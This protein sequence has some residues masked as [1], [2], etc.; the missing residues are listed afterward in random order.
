[1][2]LT[3]LLPIRCAPGHHHDADFR[4]Y[5][6]WVDG[7]S[8][9]LVVDG[10]G[11]RELDEH[12]SVVPRSARHFAPDPDLVFRNG[13]VNGVTTGVRRASHEQVVIADDDVRYDESSLSAVSRLLEGGDLVVPQN[14]FS[15]RPWHARW[16]EARSLINRAIGTDYPGT[17]AV[18]RSRFLAM[19][20]Y[21]GDVLFE[22]LELMRTV[23][24]SGGRIVLA[25]DVF[26]PRRPP[27]A[28]TFL[29]QRIRQAYDDFAQ[30]LRLAAFLSL[31][32]L[33]A[34]AIVRRRREVLVAFAASAMLLAEAGRR[35]AGGRAVY[36]PSSALMAPLWV[37]E[38]AVCSWA[39]VG[40]RVRGGARYRGSRLA[41]AAT[42]L[43]DLRRRARSLG[44]GI[45]RDRTSS[46]ERG[47][48]SVAQ[49]FAPR[50]SAAAE[51]DDVAPHHDL[52]PGGVEQP[53]RATNEI[54]TV[55]VDGH[56]RLGS[57]HLG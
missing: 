4:D 12:R 19:G 27:D 29:D 40:A 8:E 33:L 11:A 7:R 18:R 39:A 38:R 48:G 41:R 22:N 51:G 21:D 37:L 50:A 6:A 46:G 49:R 52:A 3:Y 16:D 5:L 9:L 26:V 2:P 42:P 55:R 35:R 43:A 13:K 57:P 23:T 44:L 17:L 25:P 14:V 54:G 24:A 10:S 47:V 56:G 31:I 28:G 53:D 15:E 30:P 32:P 34:A 20:G 1:M 36:P 45:D